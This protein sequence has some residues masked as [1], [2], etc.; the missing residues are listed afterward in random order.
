MSVIERG[1]DGSVCQKA[2]ACWWYFVTL[3]F[4]RRHDITSERYPAAPSFVGRQ[5]ASGL[6]FSTST[7]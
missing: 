1:G 3:T 4:A 2:E 7:T 6:A 5:H